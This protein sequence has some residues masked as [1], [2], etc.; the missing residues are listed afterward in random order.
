MCLV[1]GTASGGDISQK[2]IKIRQNSANFHS[3][4][5]AVTATLLDGGSLV[6][7]DSLEVTDSNT[8]TQVLNQP[9]VGDLMSDSVSSLL[10]PAVFQEDPTYI[11]KCAAHFCRRLRPPAHLAR[12]AEAASLSDARLRSRQS[13]RVVLKNHKWA[14]ND[15]NLLA[16]GA[17]RERE[18]ISI[19][20]ASCQVYVYWAVAN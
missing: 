4:S 12:F 9:L 8:F 17:D 5:F 14:L 3:F 18:I 15:F 11:P 7:R 10:L 6:S 1:S 16:R 2:S 13:T 19:N 20:C